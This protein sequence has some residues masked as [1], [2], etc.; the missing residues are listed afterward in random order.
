MGHFV[1]LMFHFCNLQ[2]KKL[3]MNDNI[4]LLHL[5]RKKTK[6][7]FIWPHTGIFWS[8]VFTV[9]INLCKDKMHQYHGYCCLL[10]SHCL[11]TQRPL[12][13][14]WKRACCIQRTNNGYKRGHAYCHSS[15]RE[16]IKIIHLSLVVPKIE[17]HLI[18]QWKANWNS[19]AFPIDPNQRYIAILN[20]WRYQYT[21]QEKRIK[22]RLF[23][24]NWHQGV[25]LIF[26][27]D[28][29]LAPKFFKVVANSKKVGHH[30]QR[31][32]KPFFTL[33]AF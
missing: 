3:S 2:K 12:F 17:F 19:V 14:I 22:C 30:F 27:S 7:L 29:H 8:I 24:M 23:T 31:Q 33:S 1:Y 26:F 11:I 32:T 10:C 20:K 28:S 13:P 9:Y 18:L 4:A 6:T 21:E 16:N 15:N 5:K 25:K